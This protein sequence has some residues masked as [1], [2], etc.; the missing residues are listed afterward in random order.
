MQSQYCKDHTDKYLPGHMHDQYSDN[1]TCK[2]SFVFSHSLQVENVSRR[3]DLGSKW[4]ITMAKLELSVDLSTK[5]SNS[6]ATWSHSIINLE[7]EIYHSTHTLR[8]TPNSNQR[9]KLSIK[10]TQA[11]SKMPIWNILRKCEIRVSLASSRSPLII[12]LRI[13]LWNSRHSFKNNRV[14][15]NKI[16]LHSLRS[17]AIKLHWVIRV[18]MPAAYSMR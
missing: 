6:Y 4:E 3:K 10:R 14:D 17:K 7:V 1:L 18:T 5:K 11:F 13:K 12:P 2:S 16:F 8:R 15:S 9:L